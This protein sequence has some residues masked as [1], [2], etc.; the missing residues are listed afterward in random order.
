MSEPL[1][2]VQSR[3]PNG[4]TVLSWYESEGG[5]YQDDYIAEVSSLALLTTRHTPPDVRLLA[6]GLFGNELLRDSKADLSFLTTHHQ[7]EPGGPIEPNGA[8]R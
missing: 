7:T 8:L 4:H 2:I 1:V 5:A 3:D 6:Y